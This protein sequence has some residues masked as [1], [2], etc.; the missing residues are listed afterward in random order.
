MK[1]SCGFSALALFV[2]LASSAFAEAPRKEV[3]S[4]ISAATVYLDRA[5]VTRQAHATLQPGIQS[6]AFS[7]LPFFLIDNSV[8]VS[9][10]G[11]TAKIIDVRIETQ[12]M[13]TVPEE[14]LRELT[15]KLTQLREEMQEI[16]D[17]VSTVTLE[18]EFLLQIKAQSS[19]NISKDLKIQRPTVEDWQKVIQFLDQNLTKF[20]AELRKLTKDR[21]V[22]Q[23]KID[24]LQRQIDL[25]GS[26]HQRAAKSVVVQIEA[27]KS[28][29]IDLGVTYMVPNARW[30]P[31]YDIRVAAESKTVELLYAG[32]V[33]QSTGE[34]WENVDLSLSTARPDLGGVKP[35]LSPWYVSLSEPMRMQKSGLMSRAD[36]VEAAGAAAQEMAVTM[37][38][39]ESEVRTQLVATEFHI[40]APATI[41]S[42]NA[43]HRVVVTTAELSGERSNASVPKLTPNAY[44]KAAV[45]NSTDFPFLPGAMNIY[46]GNDFVASSF[47]KAVAPGELFDAYLGVDPLIKVE[48]KLLNKVTEYVGTFTKSVRVTY[49]F[50]YTV[51]NN[52]TTPQFLAVQDQLPLSQNEKISVTQIEPAEKEMKKDDLGMLVWNLTLAPSEKKTWKFVFSIEYPQGTPVAGLE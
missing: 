25:I 30:V 15:G 2:F 7:N 43:P 29:S 34:D 13:D 52:H 3:A 16:A 20:S 48:R 18:R 35:E 32:I 6:L 21:T 5:S 26:R 24:A 50:R 8:R 41:L 45:K 44:A 31:Q 14:R 42:D 51:E 46:A 33:L 9:G 39:V 1:K 47:M 40:K 17:R 49:E 22:L 10:S 12:Q 36:R 11:I 19:D 27:A 28:G 4:S 23:E 38:A 37:N